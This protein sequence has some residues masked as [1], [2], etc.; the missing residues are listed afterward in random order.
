MRW[1]WGPVLLWSGLLLYPLAVAAS[2]N[3]AFLQDVGAT[4]VLA[5]ISACAWNIVG[6][7]AGQVSVGHAIFFG[8]GAYLP[9]LVYH[10][11][12]LPPLVGV[13]M[14]SAMTTATSM[15]SG[16]PTSGGACQS[17]YMSSDV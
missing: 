13:P 7:Y 11:W 15:P 2:D 6:G 14:T 16:S 5:A 1:H 8:A 12:Q 17:S 9:L 3:A 10:H 4:L